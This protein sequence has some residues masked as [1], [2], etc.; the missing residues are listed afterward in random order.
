ME[1]RKAMFE[2][3]TRFC[4]YIKE[5]EI[6]WIEKEYGAKFVCWCE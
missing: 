1:Y 3:G 2:L 4:L 5:S 6:T